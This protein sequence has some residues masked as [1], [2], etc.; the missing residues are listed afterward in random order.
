M[1]FSR[2]RSVSGTN[3]TNRTAEITIYFSVPNRFIA[4][5]VATFAAFTISIFGSGQ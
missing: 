3:N 4:A 2:F 1:N 5:L